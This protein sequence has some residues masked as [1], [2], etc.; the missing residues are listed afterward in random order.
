VY[1]RPAVSLGVNGLD[2]QVH[3]DPLVAGDD[4]NM[5]SYF[6]VPDED[7]CLFG[8]E[9]KAEPNHN[10]TPFIPPSNSPLGPDTILGAPRFSS[11]LDDPFS[12]VLFP[13]VHF[14]SGASFE[15]DDF[16]LAAGEERLN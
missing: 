13:N 6:N 10:V 7:F 4:F 5:G 3:S 2:K 12:D 16:D 15:C 9:P 1:P 8:D 14:G 11:T